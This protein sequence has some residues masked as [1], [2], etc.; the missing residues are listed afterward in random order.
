[1]Q[2]GDLFPAQD[3]GF[4]FGQDLDLF[5][6]IAETKLAE[7]VA[8][9]VRFN[10]NVDSVF[11]AHAQLMVQGFPFDS[12]T[13]EESKAEFSRRMGVPWDDMAVSGEDRGRLFK[14]F[15][16][17]LGGLASLYERD[18]SGP[19]LMG[20]RASYAD[21]IV[22]GWLRMSRG[23]LAREEWEALKKWHSGVFGKLH[24]ALKVFAQMD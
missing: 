1:M 13:A 18:A 6:P 14:S 17:S 22:G 20:S 3:L 10:T 9:Y 2:A 5:A 4:V 23:M 15:E 7:H 11:S 12:A 8:A 21:F 24:E 19:F 16:E